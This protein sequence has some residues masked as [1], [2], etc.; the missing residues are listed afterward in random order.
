MRVFFDTVFTLF[1]VTAIP[2]FAQTPEPAGTPGPLA[3]NYRPFRVDLGMG[4]ATI[5]S[6]GAHGVGMSVEPKFNF[7]DQ[8]SG[9]FRV[10]MMVSQGVDVEGPTGETVETRQQVVAA[11]MV[12]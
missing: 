9:G 8:L 3:P 4:W 5:P 7:L 1:F 12:K 6:Q 10:D 11:A 2:A